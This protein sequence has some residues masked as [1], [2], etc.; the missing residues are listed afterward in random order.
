[1]GFFDKL[2]ELE[3]LQTRLAGS[4]IELFEV[5]VFISIS[6]QNKDELEELTKFVKTKATKFQVTINYLNRQQEKGMNSILP[7]GVNHLG[8]AVSTYLLTD[9]AAVLIPF[10]YR[11][12]YQDEGV[13]YGINKVTN[14]AIILDR[15]EEMNANGYV[16][17]PSGSG[18]SMFVKWMFYSNIRQMKLSSLILKM[19][20]VFLLRKRT[21]TVRFL[22]FRLTRLQNTTSLIL[23]FHSQKKDETLLLSNLNL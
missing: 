23:T 18:K 8:N 13:F 17:G 20:T 21:L 15:T 14:S 2:K 12:Y 19:S 5:A 9:A 22:N 10:S 4:N 3:E 7:L 11:T 6:A 16:L 1:M